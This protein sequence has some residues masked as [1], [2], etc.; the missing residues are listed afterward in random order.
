[1]KRTNKISPKNRANYE[2]INKTIENLKKNNLLNSYLGNKGYTIYKVSLDEKII[3]FIKSELIAKPFVQ[4]SLVEPQS[5]PVYQESTKKIYV[6]RLWG[7]NIFGEPKFVLNESLISS[8]SDMMAIPYSLSEYR[9]HI[10]S[11]SLSLICQELTS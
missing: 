4:S 8:W 9:F 3:N 6:P 11:D 7:L 10:P 1:M 5:F 2:E